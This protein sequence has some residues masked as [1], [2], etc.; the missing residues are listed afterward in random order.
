MLD[1]VVEYLSARNVVAALAVVLVL[2][3]VYKSVQQ[4][5]KIR[6]LGG[7]APRRKN[8]LPFGLDMIYSGVQSSRRH[9]NLQ[10]WDNNFM[11]FGN[12][13]NPYTFESTIGTQRVVLTVD[14]ENIKAILATQ[15]NDYGKGPGFNRD[16]HDFLGDSIFSTD[17]ELWH[18][19][20][21]LIRPQF[22]KDRVSD[23]H[24]F[25]KHVEILIPLLKGNGQVVDVKNLFFRYTLDAATD[26]LLGRSVESLERGETSFAVAFAEIQRIQNQFARAGP[27]NVLMSRKEFYAHLKTLNNF[28]EPY[29]D[30]TLAL[31]QDELEKRSKGEQGYTFLHAL[32]AYTRDRKVLRDQLVAVLLA[33]R[34]T[35]ACTLTWI[36]YELSK[37]PK[38]VAE[39]RKEIEDVVGLENAPT[40]ANL[41]AMKLLQN[42]MHETL[43][44]YPV[45]PFNVRE[46][47]RDCT[48][49]HGGGPDGN[50]PIGILKGTPI[51]YSTHY[52]QLRADIYPPTSAEFP[53]PL[54]FDPHRWEH[55]SPAPWRYIP[56]NGGPRLCVGQQFALTEMS[57]TMV[58]IFQRFSRVDCHVPAKHHDGM[59]EEAR[60]AH[61]QSQS[62]NGLRGEGLSSV[63]CM[64]DSRELTYKSEIVLQPAEEVKL[65]FWE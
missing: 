17:H 52:M 23:L 2:S 15:F 53:D 3:Y 34:D 62:G 47:L 45:V 36:F 35:T 10:F 26:F 50:S 60:R 18:Q 1:G 55:W 4:E 5:L 57:Y 38:L 58:R 14:P 25:E 39:L 22:I 30:D 28:V 19:S 21:Q 11:H 42:I 12:P 64:T 41:K 59:T 63:R 40:Y 27:L 7:H 49:P 56:F 32:A 16:W 33:G 8:R 65:A 20:R 9:E 48:L 44:L 6:R 24:T 13:Q 31:S 61:L 46:S 54:I 51:G 43:R 29:I 37:A